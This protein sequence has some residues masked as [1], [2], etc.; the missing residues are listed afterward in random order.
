MKMYFLICGVM[1]L[2]YLLRVWVESNDYCRKHPEIT[3]EKTSFSKRVFTL[4][5]LYCFFC[6]PVVNVISF[7]Y[8]VY[9]ADNKFYTNEIEKGIVK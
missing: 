4:F 9:I 2:V 5:Q 3:L 1:L 6:L 7:V 8:L